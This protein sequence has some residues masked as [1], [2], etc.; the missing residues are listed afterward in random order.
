MNISRI[1][2]PVLTTRSD[3][4]KI[5]ERENSGVRSITLAR[6]AI[7]YLLSGTK[8]IHCNDRSY[9]VVEGDVFLLD[10]GF[11]YEENI[12]GANGRFEQITFYL[13]P[14]ML[15]QVI[16]GL[17]S[18]YGVSFLSHHT[19]S[20]CM[21][22]NFVVSG[23]DTLLQSFFVGVDRSLRN[24]GLQHSDVRQLIKLN[25]LV[26]LILSGEDGCLRRKLLRSADTALY[27]F[28]TTIHS[29]I[30]AD[31]SIEALATATNRS[32]T[33]FKKDFKRMFATSPHRWV[34][35]QRLMRAR[36]L[37]VSTNHTVSEIGA[38][39]GFSNISHFIKLFKQRYNTTPAI[40]RMR[41]S[42][43]SADGGGAVA[44]M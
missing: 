19:C 41:H 8:Y 26:Y 35:E 30:F 34:V 17:S 9:P 11:H 39:C 22:Q 36:I 37:L 29:N 6:I 42:M 44:S 21:S 12:V 33:S 23:G 1:E 24:T 40:F 3:V 25:E 2:N 43:V 10:M 16:F 18:N 7:G 32:L 38:E 13:S 31:V 5:T 14:D 28:V 15:Q 27:H 20:Q 4:V